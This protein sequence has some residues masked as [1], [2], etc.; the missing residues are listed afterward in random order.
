[1]NMIGLE[2]DWEGGHDHVTGAKDQNGCGAIAMLFNRDS[3]D[4]N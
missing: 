1:M 2:G 3:R 4:V